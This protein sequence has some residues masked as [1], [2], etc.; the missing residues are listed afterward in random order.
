VTL[1]RW[2]ALWAAVTVAVAVGQFFATDWAGGLNPQARCES[3]QLTLPKVTGVRE[4]GQRRWPPA[5]RCMA[6]ECFTERRGA[7]GESCPGDSRTAV[8]LLPARASDWAFLLLG[9]MLFT[10]LIAGMTMITLR[11]RSG[12]ARPS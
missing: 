6:I 3:L 8:F 5:T 7:D 12:H 11:W 4:V 10:P 2:L 9:S 1:A